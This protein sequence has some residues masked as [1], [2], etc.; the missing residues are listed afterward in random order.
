[1][2]TARTD[3]QLDA[4]R[5]DLLALA[6]VI[7]SGD[8]WA[9]PSHDACRRCDSREICPS[10]D[11]A[12]AAQQSAPVRASRPG[13][14]A[15]SASGW[16]ERLAH[17]PA[18]GASAVTAASRP[19]RAISPRKRADGWIVRSRVERSTPIRPNRIP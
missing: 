15:G 13:S 2:S 16:A 4:A 14:S 18:G 5:D 7:R 10:S 12:H 1:M 17:Y 19:V 6:A 9:T 3:E 11:G 8:F